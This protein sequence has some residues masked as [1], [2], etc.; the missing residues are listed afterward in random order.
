MVNL[1]L[2]ALG[3]SALVALSVLAPLMNLVAIAAAVP[4]VFSV[5][6]SARR[7]FAS[8]LFVALTLGWVAGA[9]QG[10]LRAPLLFSLL[11]VVGLTRWAVPRFPLQSV[12]GLAGWC[13]VSVVVADVVFVGMAGLVGGDAQLAR[14]LVRV[15]PPASLVSGALALPLAWLL[16]AVEPHLRERRERSTLLR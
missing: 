13:M 10:G 3:V 4:V 14:M 6:A 11:A 15:T 1:L 9:M 7:D 2:V 5:Y 12:W 16:G 8:G